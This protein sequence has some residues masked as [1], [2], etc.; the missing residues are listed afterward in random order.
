MMIFLDLTKA[1]DTVSHRILQ[2]KLSRIGIRGVVGNFF[3]KYLDKRSQKVK[4]GEI[5][6]DSCQVGCGVPQ[7]TVLGHF[8][9]LLTT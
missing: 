4:I 3:K 6:S 1:F 7:G 8:L 2:D 9:F 5:L